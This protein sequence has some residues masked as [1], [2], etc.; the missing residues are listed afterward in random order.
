MCVCVNMCISGYMCTTGHVWR[1][2]YNFQEL[3]VSFYHVG[4]RDDAQVIRLDSKGF[5]QLSHLLDVVD[6]HRL[7][8]K[9]QAY[10]LYIAKLAMQL[11]GSWVQIT[12]VDINI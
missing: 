1:S 3:V 10:S 5:Y 11:Y 9:L 2:Q 4:L 7:G 6:F 12:R 8:Q